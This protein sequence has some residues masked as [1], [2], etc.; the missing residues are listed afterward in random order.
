MKAHA[1]IR[2]IKVPMPE[3]YRESYASNN[4]DKVPK[5]PNLRRMWGPTL[6]ALIILAAINT[7]SAGHIVPVMKY[8]FKIE[9]SGADVALG[10]IGWAGFVG[11]TMAIVFMMMQPERT[12]FIIGTVG[13]AFTIELFMNVASTLIA[14][15]GADSTFSNLASGIGLGIF[16]P[17]AN[18]A[19][20]EVLHN[21]GVRQA[22]KR[23]SVEQ[24]YKEQVAAFTAKWH[25]SYRL[26]YKR[27]GL[28]DDEI[29]ALLRGDMDYLAEDEDVA[30]AEQRK[31]PE[32]EPSPAAIDLAEMLV[33]NGDQSESYAILQKR[34]SKSAAT[35]RDAKRYLSL[36]GPDQP[37]Q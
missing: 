32:W 5:E 20:G 24:E 6:I 10:F 3:N 35:V 15:E 33:A 36:S 16:I 27:A 25:R 37:I 12:K 9:G 30:P 26:R 2:G 13:L 21:I 14:L 28:T 8:F 17:C 29:D 11:I 34:Y 4:P 22:A 18:I 31:E 7:M 23:S 1:E 19:F